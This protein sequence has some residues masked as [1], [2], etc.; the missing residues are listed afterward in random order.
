MRWLPL[1]LILALLA[2]R[3]F[4]DNPRHAPVSSEHDA[5]E[6]ALERTTERYPQPKT[7][8]VSEFRCDG[9]TRCTQMTS[10]VEAT[11]FLHNCPGT[12][13]DGDRDG[14]P[15]ESQWCGGG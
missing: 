14:I 4:A 5:D 12:E 6:G 3:G 9:R 2:W 15:C 8:A 13:M 1:V 10:C 7:T 11:F